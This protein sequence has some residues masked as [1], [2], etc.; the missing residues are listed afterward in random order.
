MCLCCINLALLW[1][2]GREGL[3]FF[4]PSCVILCIWGKAKL[5]QQEDEHEC[6][7]QSTHLHTI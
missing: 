6:I 4:V 3:V 1:Q 2:K 7:V 5:S